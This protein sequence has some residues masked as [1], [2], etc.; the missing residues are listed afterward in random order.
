MK[1]FPIRRYTRSVRVKQMEIGANAPISIQSMTNTD[2]HNVEDTYRQIKEL[3]Q[4]GCDI[5]RLALP[6][7]AACETIYRLKERGIT[8]PLVA[9]IHFDYRIAL[10]AAAAGIDKIRIN[11]GNIGDEERIKAVAGECRKRRIPIRIGINS[12][13]LE[14]NILEKYG[15]PTP[16]AMAESALFHAKLLEKYDFSDIVLSIKSS[17]VLSMIEAN[18]IVGAACDYPL[19]LGVTEAGRGNAGMLK[20]AIGIGT[21]LCEG[22]GDTIRVSLTDSPLEEVKAAK[23]ILRAIGLSS[24][25]YIN[26]VSC[27]T[28]GRTKIDLIPICEELDRRLRNIPVNKNLTVAVMGCVVNG[29]G[30][31][32]QADIGIAGAL[33]E[34]VLFSHGKV[35]RR[36]QEKNLVDELVCEIQKLLK[37]E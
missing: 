17:D 13:S 24:E 3:E 6:D 7:V 11:P 32:A 18:R 33:G 15:S 12:G 35:I 23:A 4:E 21:L 14:K 16:E 25:P 36:V 28:C 9:D 1:T 19:H 5:V 26:V 37:S 2:P 29:P 27:P 8:V 34:A 22:I 31:A 20:S 30:E 10:A